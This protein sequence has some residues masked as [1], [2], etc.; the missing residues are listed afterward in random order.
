[1]AG[2]LNIKSGLAVD[3][4]NIFFSHLVYDHAKCGVAKA[5]KIR[6]RFRLRSNNNGDEGLSLGRALVIDLYNT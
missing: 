6:S 5:L 4:F 2:I 1:M 3:F